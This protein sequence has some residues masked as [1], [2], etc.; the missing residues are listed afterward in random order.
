MSAYIP[1]SPPVDMVMSASWQP[2]MTF[3]QVIPVVIALWLGVRRWL[4][5]DLPLLAAIFVGGA[6][7]CLIEPI[8]DRGSFVWFATKG[9][10]VMFTTFDR[11]MPWFILPCYLWFIGGQVAYLIYRIRI[12]VTRGQLWRLYGIFIGLNL[13]M[14]LP[15]IAAGIYAYYGPQPFE[16]AGL[17][18]WFQAINSVTSLLAAAVVSYMWPRL[19]GWRKLVTPL[20]LPCSHAITNAAAGWPVQTSLN[21]T[22]NML[23]VNLT[24]LLTIGIAVGLAALAIAFLVRQSEIAAQ[25]DDAASTA[26]VVPPVLDS[27]VTESDSPATPSAPAAAA[28]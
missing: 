20:I 28:T 21:T 22:D 6:L 11:P 1:P 9:M 4:P 25:R 7:T 18:L 27:A 24:G 3:I 8:T 26:D 10:W 16:I 13:A 5:K 15:A 12:G 23:V 19:R 14:E 2:I 17:P